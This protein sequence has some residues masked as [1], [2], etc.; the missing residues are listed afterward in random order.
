M[1]SKITENTILLVGSAASYAHGVIDPIE[2]I[3]ALAQQR[4]ALMHVDACIGGWMLSAMRHGGLEVPRFGL[5]LPGVTSLSVDLHKYGFAP[6]GIS[7]LLQRRRELRDAQ[8]YACGTWTGYTIVNST[9][10]GSKSLAALGAA[11]AVLRKV[12]RRGFI[13]MARSMWEATEELIEGIHGVPGLKVLGSPDM[14]LLAF[15]SEGDLFELAD[16][17]HARGW[18]IQPTYAFGSSPAHIHLGL[19][20]GNAAR[21]GDFLDDLHECAEDLPPA[22]APPQ[23]FVQLLEGLAAG[24][25]GGAGGGGVDVGG[26]MKEMGIVDG[27]LPGSS[28]MIHRLLN[29]ASPAARAGLLTLFIGELF[30]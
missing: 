12:G 25:A 14:G 28:A 8:Y 15:V 19:T 26:L 7:V 5:E 24:A 21:M 20:P 10:L 6:K 1:R 23:A 2:E 29:A 17:L 11:W 9:T 3:A 27:K 13:D 4:G 18:Y 30:T 16:R 22:S